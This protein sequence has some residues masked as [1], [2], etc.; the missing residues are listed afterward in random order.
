EKIKDFQSRGLFGPRDIHKTIVKLPFPRYNSQDQLHKNLSELGRKCADRVESWGSQN[1]GNDLDARALGRT[2]TKIRELLDDLLLEINVV[3]ET[4]S[5][6]KS[7]AAVRASGKG[8]SRRGGKT[9]PL[10]G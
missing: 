6:G 2:R 4:L 7:E 9:L 1:E 8:R 3:V 10:F 5:T